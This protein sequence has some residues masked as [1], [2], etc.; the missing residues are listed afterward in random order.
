VSRDALEAADCRRH[1]LHRLR[2]PRS[3]NDGEQ[4]ASVLTEGITGAYSAEHLESQGLDAKKIEK[5]FRT[6]ARGYDV[7]SIGCTPILLLASHLPIADEL[8]W[9]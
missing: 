8:R 6:L 2:H 7:R 5:F 3:K 4:L 9:R 1:Y